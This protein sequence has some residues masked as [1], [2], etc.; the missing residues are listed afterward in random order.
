MAR[1]S[2]DRITDIWKSNVNE[3]LDRLEE[4]EKMA[5]QLVRDMEE[6]V[7]RAAAS[8][9]AAVANQRRLERECETHR[10]RSQE[11]QQRAE[12]A[13]AAGDEEEARKALERKTRCDR[14]AEEA[15]PA[16]EES[17]QVAAELRE[18]L[19]ELGARLREARRR[20][21]ALIARYQAAQARGG[22]TRQQAGT[23]EDT[24]TD[25]QRLE[26]QIRTHER[27]FERLVE[28]VETAEARAEVQQELAGE[29]G[30]EEPRIQE[31]EMGERV[32]EELAELKR[33]ASESE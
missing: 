6:E 3:L 20:Q 21:G 30:R 4:P 29:L 9:A 32:E 12:R 23:G 27:A 26:Q 18:Q 10:T 11:W 8:V 15:Q 24:R 2:I 1:N 14:A 16:L 13:L 22:Q 28:Q 17:R 33:K 7:D 31:L 19:R 25:F 5:R